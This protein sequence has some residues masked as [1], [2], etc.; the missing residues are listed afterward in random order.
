MKLVELP[1]PVLLALAM[2][3]AIAA[4]AVARVV[5]AHV[6]WR[7]AGGL[8]L[9]AATPL[10]PH[11]PILGGFSL[12]DVLPLVAVAMLFRTLRPEALRRL[13]PSRI[14]TAGLLLTVGAAVLASA[15]N[16]A[17]PVHFVALA[18]RG[19]GR[20]V[21]LAVVVALTVLAQPPERRTPLVAV[22][23]AILGTA[24]AIFGLA[25]FVLP[26]GG[27]GLSPTRVHSIL[28]LEVPGRIAGTLGI[29]PNFLGAIFIL[30]IALTAGLALDARG[31]RQRV[32]LWACVALQTLALTL[33]FTRA[34]L[35]LA[36][37]VLVVLVVARGRLLYLAP[38]VLAVVVGLTATPALHRLTADVP[39]RLALWTSAV[40][41]MADHP[42]AGVG[43]GRSREVALQHAERYRKTVFGPAVANAHNTVLIAGAETG[44]GGAAGV[45]MLNLAIGLAAL[46]VL[47]L[48]RGQRGS[49]VE[50]AG[51]LAVLAYLVQGQVN[52]LLTVAACG[53]LFAVVVGAFLGPALLGDVTISRPAPGA[54]QRDRVGAG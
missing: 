13:R 24:E 37:V 29:S 12:D 32:S 27:L 33:T 50:T 2:A 22:S 39:D 25:T 6:D 38:T 17:D 20:Y 36:L 10:V 47:W 9:V 16:A 51:V 46:R 30:T 28:Y 53:T 42:I 5:Q 44:I 31:T 15:V 3:I 26:M 18:T 40:T 35:G 52:N 49:A 14:V 34:S 4:L 19:A 45:L 23:L 8:V 1:T 48:N 21:L 41:M 43:P 11:V 7:P 54:A